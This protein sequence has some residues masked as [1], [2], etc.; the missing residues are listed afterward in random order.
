MLGARP[1]PNCW[2]T[3]QCAPDPEQEFGGVN[4][5]MGNGWRGGM[6]RTTAGLSLAGVRVR[7]GGV[8]MGLR[9]CVFVHMIV[10]GLNGVSS[11]ALDGA[12]SN[13]SWQLTAVGAGRYLPDADN[14]ANRADLAQACNVLK[15]SLD[16]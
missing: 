7:V 8:V 14:S 15:R 13:P 11:V 10:N 1:G 6:I 2:S 9:M 4:H 16:S 12:A 3:G 5:G